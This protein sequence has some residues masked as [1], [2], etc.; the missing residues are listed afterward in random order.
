MGILSNCSSFTEFRQRNC[1][2]P[3]EY[4]TLGQLVVKDLL[5]HHYPYEESVLPANIRAQLAQCHNTDRLEVT[6]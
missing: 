4:P 6:E 2:E 5:V 3:P 1:L